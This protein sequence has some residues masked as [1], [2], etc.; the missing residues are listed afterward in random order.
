MK[1]QRKKHNQLYEAQL[2]CG[3]MIGGGAIR[4]V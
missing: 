1:I 2:E 4:I 3:Q